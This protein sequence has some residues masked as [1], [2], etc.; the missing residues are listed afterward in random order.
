MNIFIWALWKIIP[1][2][3]VAFTRVIHQHIFSS[4]N[5]SIHLLCLATPTGWAVFA[6]GSADLSK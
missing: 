3:A 5:I 4:L 6:Y 1:E 2:P